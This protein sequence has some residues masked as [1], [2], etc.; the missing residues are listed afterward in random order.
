[1]V[2]NR[3]GLKERLRKVVFEK[4]FFAQHQAGP[5]YDFF[6]SCSLPLFEGGLG[7]M[8]HGTGG[9]AFVNGGKFPTAE[10]AGIEAAGLDKGMT[11]KYAGDLIP[12]KFLEDSFLLTHDESINADF[13]GAKM[14]I[15]DKNK[16]RADEIAERKQE[17]GAETVQLFEAAGAFVDNIIAVNP[18]DPRGE[19]LRRF[20]NT[21]PDSNTS[22][23]KMTYVRSITEKVHCLPEG[24]PYHGSG[25]PSPVTAIGLVGAW[26]K[27]RELHF[28]GENKLTIGMKGGA[29]SV[30]SNAIRIVREYEASGYL[31]FSID[32]KVSDVNDERVQVRLRNLRDQYG[33]ETCESGTEHRDVHIFSPNAL[34]G[35][36]TLQVAQELRKRTA[37]VGAE[38]EQLPENPFNQKDPRILTTVHDIY[39]ALKKIEGYYSP[40]FVNNNGG[41]HD[42]NCRI[43]WGRGG[44]SKER[45]IQTMLLAG[46][47]YVGAVYERV[48]E[49][50]EG[51]RRRVIQSHV[52]AE[53]MAL[54][55]LVDRVIE[56]REEVLKGPFTAYF[57]DVL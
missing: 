44:Y 25:D 48:K 18:S 6:V 23:I 46:Q 1:M 55:A 45:A 3:Q 16:R 15:R 54:D 4:Q 38:N 42:V 28:P 24:A 32:F 11:R 8:R 21:A 35:S 2:A 17:Y 51:D 43:M 14:V 39:S 22:S 10:S 20:Y 40:D 33:F 53:E 27:I 47:Y 30:A 19:P 49:I 13:L 41:I 34:I 37:I 29:G 50:Q 36:V 9:V 52:I 5:D 56:R 7:G 26:K 31:G 57:A 12:R